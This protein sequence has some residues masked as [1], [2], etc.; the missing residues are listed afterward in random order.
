M[1]GNLRAQNFYEVVQLMRAK[2]ETHRSK[3]REIQLFQYNQTRS[4]KIFYKLKKLIFRQKDD[5]K[6]IAF[7][8]SMSKISRITLV[9]YCKYCNLICYCTR[10]LLLK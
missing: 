8:L 10:Y 2:P 6:I 3:E 1:L 9:Y 7:V 4:N 5:K